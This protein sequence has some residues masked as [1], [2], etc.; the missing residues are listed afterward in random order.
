MNNSSVHLL[1]AI[2]SLFVVI[3]GM[4]NDVF[5]EVVHECCSA[6]NADEQDVVVHFLQIEHVVQI[7]LM[8]HLL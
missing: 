2:D 6:F 7:M 3:N 8:K 1:V 5:G 4:S